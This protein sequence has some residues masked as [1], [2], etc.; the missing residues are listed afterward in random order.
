MSSKQPK[1]CELFIIDAYLIEA[2]YPIKLTTRDNY[3]SAKYVI[4]PF[5]LPQAECD[6]KSILKW[7][8]TGLN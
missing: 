5:F 3:L 2:N 7:N 8:K 6:T 4:Y 1:G